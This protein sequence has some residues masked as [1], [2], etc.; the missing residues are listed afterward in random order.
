MY[1]E[2]PVGDYGYDSSRIPGELPSMPE[3]MERY[4]ALPLE[5][6]ITE[7][8][9]RVPVNATPEGPVAEHSP[10]DDFPSYYYSAPSEN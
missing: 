6:R 7:R 3:L 10:R 9:L 1:Y 5:L 8:L 2:Q 4:P